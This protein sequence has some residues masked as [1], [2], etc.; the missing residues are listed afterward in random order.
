MSSVLFQRVRSLLAQIREN[1][2]EVK[3]D[4]AKVVKEDKIEFDLGEHEDCYC[5][6][7]CGPIAGMSFKELKRM[8]NSIKD[9]AGVQKVILIY[10]HAIPMDLIEITEENNS[11]RYISCSGLPIIRDLEWRWRP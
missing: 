8:V 11:A 5:P 6:G 9:F 2:A 3:Q 1:Q 4:L 7:C 10:H